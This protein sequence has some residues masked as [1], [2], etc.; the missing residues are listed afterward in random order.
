MRPKT[1]TF[2][3]SFTHKYEYEMLNA[4]NNIASYCLIICALM[5]RACWTKPLCRIHIV[6]MCSLFCF[7]VIMF[8]TYT[9]VPNMTWYYLFTYIIHLHV[10]CLINVQ[11]AP[12]YHNIFLIF[13]LFG[14]F[15]FFPNLILS[16]HGRCACCL[17]VYNIPLFNR[18]NGVAGQYIL[19][20]TVITGAR[21]V[22]PGGQ[23]WLQKVHNSRYV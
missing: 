2:S 9:L 7:C 11:C 12:E 4:H 13:L 10:I 3:I 23:I 14:R 19:G 20:S 5:Y 15:F 6:C 16:S 8:L 17:R 21:G 22:L 18:Y 1:S